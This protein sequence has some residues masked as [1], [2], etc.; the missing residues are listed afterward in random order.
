MSPLQSR[1]RRQAWRNAS[2]SARL[3]SRYQRILSFHRV[4]SVEHE[5]PQPIGVARRER[6]AEERPVG[7]AVQV[8]APEPERVEDERKVVS[9]ERGAVQIGPR[10]E[11]RAAQSHVV[12]VVAPVR[13]ERP[14]VDRP[15]R[16]CAAVVD[17]EQVAP[18]EKWLEEVEVAVPAG[19]GRIPG[20]A[21][22]GDDRAERGALTIA[23]LRGARARPVASPPSDPPDR[24]EPGRVHS[25]HRRQRR[26]GASSRPPRPGPRG[27]G[28]PLWRR[29][30]AIVSRPTP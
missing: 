8:D 7:V 1:S 30:R 17:E 13:L 6:L 9:G 22:G 21:L 2:P 25:G 16:S 4:G 19:R 5:R 26:R 23:P 14:A 24:A 12:D 28:H 3:R 15:R 29:A 27:P 11:L 20:A 18:V 10:A